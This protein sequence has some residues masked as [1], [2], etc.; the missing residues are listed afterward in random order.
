MAGPALVRM[1][2]GVDAVG[3][4]RAGARREKEASA[5]QAGARRLEGLRGS[6]FGS[7]SGGHPVL[8]ADFQFAVKARHE[9]GADGMGHDVSQ[10]AAVTGGSRD[11]E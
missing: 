9:F 3:G 5:W 11:L 10:P 2:S 4:G 6:G 1:E 7:G 8:L